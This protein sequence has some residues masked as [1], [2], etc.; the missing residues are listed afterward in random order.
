MDSFSLYQV[1]KTLETHSSVKTLY[2]DIEQK[3]DRLTILINNIAQ[4]LRRPSGF[5]FHFIS[6]IQ[7]VLI[8]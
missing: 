8:A 5:Y 1:F 2:N 4:T 7:A 3:Y 6:A